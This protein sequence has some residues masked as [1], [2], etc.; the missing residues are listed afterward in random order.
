MER[1]NADRKYGLVV[2]CFI[3]RAEFVVIIVKVK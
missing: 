2:A 3:S 1:V